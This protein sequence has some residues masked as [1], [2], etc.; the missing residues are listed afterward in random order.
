MTEISYA[1]AVDP[2]TLPFKD[3]RTSLKV[4]GV[5][6]VVFGA[7]S[8]CFG[9]LTPIGMFAAAKF[10]RQAPPGA[11]PAG[12]SF[13]PDYRMMALAG[14]TYLAIAAVMIW[15]GVGSL[16]I[17]RWVR[18]VVLVLGW[19]WLIT[20]TVSLAHWA[21]FGVNMREM[22]TASLPPGAPPP[23]RGVIYAVTALMG[24]T[25][26]VLLLVL[27]ALFIWL[28]RRR[29]VRETLEYFDRRFAWTDRCPTP[30]LAVSAW[31]ALVGAGA[32]FY[33]VF[34]V[35]PVF[36]RFLTGPAAVV[37]TL[38]TGGVFLWL[39]G[40]TY[41]LKP[42]A[43]WGAAIAWTLWA[44]SMV[45]TFTRLGY[46]EFYRQAGYSP[47][48]IDVMMRYSGQYEDSTVWMIALWSVIVIGYLLYVR[49]YFTAGSI[50]PKR[51]TV[52]PSAVS[53]GG[54]PVSQIA[55]P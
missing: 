35:F 10:A 3:R 38:A 52:D 51:A 46:H 13:E 55:P 50:E 36:G 41:R 23:P 16:R 33:S 28:Y 32:A 17:R 40:G 43:W 37:A 53:T 30:V 1:T 18:P 54:T 11:M 44:G 14:G 22:M 26:T 24:V 42:A 34:A 27:P 19:T 6:L 2:R 9:A 29:G 8:G 31:M 4:V 48:Q 12:T 21:L 45:W 25:M 15:L 7:I 47:Q 49:K 5:V 39:A 20:G